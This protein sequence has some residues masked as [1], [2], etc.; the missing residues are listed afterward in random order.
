MAL[1]LVTWL[2]LVCGLVH[3]A[4]AGAPVL[5]VALSWKYLDWV[6]P[7]VPLTK[8]PFIL[9]NAFSQDVDVDKYGRIFVTSPQWL[10]GVP[11]TLST[12]TTEVGP[13]G[14]LLKPYPNFRWHL[15]D[16]CDNLISIYRVAVNPIFCH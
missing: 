5:K 16:S 11:I 13:G 7:S 12:V 1:G 8:S 3:C 2:G 14:P 9:G 6:W 15:P 10:E 4:A